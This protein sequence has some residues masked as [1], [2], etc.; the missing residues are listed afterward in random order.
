MRL[1]TLAVAAALIGINCVSYFVFPG[2]S[3]LTS[4]TQIYV[5]MLERLWDASL[6]NKDLIATNPHL[7]FTIYDELALGARKVSGLGFAQVL[8]AMHFIFRLAGMYGIWL[9]FRAWTFS[10]LVS[11]FG[12]GCFA[13]G[14]FVHGPAVMV[15]ELEP[16]PRAMALPLLWLAI[17]WIANDRPK[18]GATAAGLALLLH[19]PTVWPVWLI[20]AIMIA[21]PPQESFRKYRW[22]VAAIL[23]SA[24]LLLVILSRLQT[25]ERE[26]Q[27]LFLLL[28]PSLESLQRMRAS[29]NWIGMWF[30]SLWKKHLLLFVAALLSARGLGVLAPRALNWFHGGLTVLGALGLGI[31]YVVLEWGKWALGPQLQFGRALVFVISWAILGS[32]AMG[33]RAAQKGRYLLSLFWFYLAYSVPVQT[34]TWEMFTPWVPTEPMAKK[35]A[36]VLGLAILAL[37]ATLVP[38]KSPAAIV[39]VVVA[40][41]VPFWALPNVLGITTHPKLYSADLTALYTWARITP[42][43]SV[44]HFPDAGQALFPG[45]FRGESARAIYVDWKSG[46]QVNFHKQLADEWWRRWQASLAKP[47]NGETSLTEYQSLPCDYV[48]LKSNHKRIGVVPVYENSTYLVYSTR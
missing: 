47:Y 20:L 26:K 30:A 32:I 19:P 41:L 38:R 34:Q 13:L 4:D 37:L 16:V 8:P 6:L 14:A 33:I 10:S 31:S 29:Y 35:M 15:W 5:P 22:H 7:S 24:V 11:L 27:Q 23:T 21:K 17:G 3:Y 36:L 18:L 2:H 44:F 39:L 12:V 40:V 1:S 28:D 42:A 46:G 48:V 45:V 25:G 43:D 9:I